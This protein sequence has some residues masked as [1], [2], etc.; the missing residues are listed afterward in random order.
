MS[1]ASQKVA[2][3]QELVDLII[4][5]V[6]AVTSDLARNNEL[7]SLMIVSRGFSLVALDA[8]WEKQTSL[9]PLFL[10]LRPV[11]RL[12]RLKDETKILRFTPG[13]KSP[14]WKR[15]YAY[16]RRIK[17]LD[18]GQDNGN[19]G[20][21]IT[22]HPSLFQGLDP[23]ST[24]LPTLQTLRLHSRV[25]DSL[26]KA[27]ALHV[28]MSAT[29]P[30]LLFVRRDLE[31]K[32]EKCR[33][34]ILGALCDVRSLRCLGVQYVP[35]FAQWLET[36]GPLH[37]LHTFE[38]FRPNG[39]Q[40]VHKSSAYLSTGNFSPSIVRLIGPSSVASA[41][42]TL[43]SLPRSATKNSVTALEISVPR[44]ADM[45]R[46]GTKEQTIDLYREIHAYCDPST[47]IHLCVFTGNAFSG[48][49]SSAR[50]LFADLLVFKNMEHLDIVFCYRHADLEDAIDAFSFA[51]P[52]LKF[53]SVVIERPERS[54]AE[55]FLKLPDFD[56]LLP[57]ARRCPCLEY[58]RLPLRLGW[59][60]YSDPPLRQS[61]AVLPLTLNVMPNASLFEPLEQRW[62]SCIAG[63][64]R[65]LFPGLRR[66]EG[67]WSGRTDLPEKFAATKEAWEEVEDIVANR[68]LRRLSRWNI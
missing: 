39:I 42:R 28:P 26:H 65:K 16:A 51:F 15:F 68:M 4:K 54:E 14:P 50:S 32:D 67:F 11:A 23:K 45:K 8:L 64:L 19:F 60:W 43:R 36:R 2:R 66:I 12:F 21:D 35:Q 56:A 61:V 18:D 27:I 44:D 31:G 55:K 1:S 48:L 59:S 40:Q 7:R 37:N 22:L 9:V 33:S 34:I 13:A 46:A 30:R 58:V 29:D 41:A 24:I 52:R 17:V 53:L 49:F 20:C 3:T 62:V 25:G 63:T 47:L 38:A 6:L 57:L 5:R 10:T